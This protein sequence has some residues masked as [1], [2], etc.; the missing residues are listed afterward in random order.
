[1]LFLII[2]NMAKFNRFTFLLITIVA[3][4]FFGFFACNFVLAQ[5]T[6]VNVVWVANYGDNAVTKF[7]S[8]GNSM[9]T[10]SV[11]ESPSGVAVDSASNMWI[12]SRSGNTVTKFDSSGNLLQTFS[13]GENPYSVATD[14][15]GNAWVAN[16]GSNTVTKVDY[17]S[18]LTETYSV[19]NYPVSVA[20]DASGNAWVANMGDNTVTELSYLG[21]LI[22]TYS[23]GENPYSVATDASGNAWV[24]NSGDDTVTKLNP[25]GKV[26]Q[27]FS[28]GSSPV[29]IAIDASGKVWVVNMG[30]NTVT[31]LD[32]SGNLMVT[33]PVGN[34]PDSLATT[35]AS[36]TRQS[37][38][39]SSIYGWAWS[40]NIG[41]IS[42][43]SLGLGKIPAGGGGNNYG[44]TIG[45]N[46]QLSGYAWSENLGWINFSPTG[47]YPDP[48]ISNHSAC[49]N[50]PGL[51]KYCD[52]GGA[53]DY[54][55]SGWVRVCSVFSDGVCGTINPTGL[56]PNT[57]GWNGWINL[58]N[59][60]LDTGV[61]PAEFHSWAWGGNDDT[62]DTQ[63]N[64]A[65]TGWV[66][67]NCY[68]G[69]NCSK[70]N[71][72]VVTGSAY[73][74][75]PL[76]A[77]CTV[78]PSSAI[79]GQ[80][81]VWTAHAIG[82][83]SPYTYKWNGAVTDSRSVVPTSYKNIGSESAN[84]TVTDSA[85]NSV[86][87]AA[88]SSATATATISI[89][90]GQIT[91]ITITNPG[92]GYTSAPTVVITGGG[93]SGA[94]ATASIDANSGT[95]SS[96]SITNPGSGC[97]SA[98]II[99]FVGG[100]GAGVV[101]SVSSNPQVPPETM[102]VSSSGLDYCSASGAYYV[103]FTWNYSCDK[104]EQVFKFQVEDKATVDST[105]AFNSPEIN[106]TVSGDS[107]S[108]SAIVS[109]SQNTGS[110]A[111]NTEYYWRVSVCDTPNDCSPWY[112]GST[113]Q[114]FPGTS[115]KTSL[116]AW[117]SVIF[118]ITPPIPIIAK[119]VL[120]ADSNALQSIQST[121]YDN[122][123]NPYYCGK[124]KTEA[125]Y[126]W[127][128]GDGNTSNSVGNVYHAYAN[129]GI[130][131]VTS[132]KICDDLGCCSA[133]SKVTVKTSLNTPQWKEVSPF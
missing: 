5:S 79:V 37:V 104:P 97:V 44:V 127:N 53:A 23:V 131:P 40:E 50:L 66:N 105:K 93:C 125:T 68:E 51:E 76:T 112:Y 63:N 74:N 86:T 90:S 13:V 1:M 101:V 30:D 88:C 43:N 9:G 24:A 49:V 46:G 55:V 62:L 57:G 8:L 78:S 21:N 12:T 94:T 96:V 28:V 85:G 17:L 83:S 72:K 42:F 47:P 52:N 102:L 114:T 126:A 110:L 10:Y 25:S 73:A 107:N 38:T 27:T 119:P 129:A 87:S 98:P 71:Y 117:P 92:S 60:T 3:F 81:V 116:H 99:T 75:F 115:F 91:N 18:N 84:V 122:S 36:D 7:D 111:F 39:A 67:F 16:S 82:G 95:I 19:G 14:A 77:F 56:D 65:V 34:T 31:E 11:S 26:L 103:R 70:N 100:G 29:A 41:W 69:G 120:F 48:A 61:S 20:T 22:N 4:Y 133:T 123:N 89:S 6:T 33:Y 118:S 121:C 35:T 130:Y 45:A 58:S 59:V 54:I 132:L 2:K 124:D 15:S 106:N 108:Q 32:S 128:F 109:A 64:E 80:S 113:T